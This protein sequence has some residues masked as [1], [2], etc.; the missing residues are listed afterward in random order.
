MKFHEAMKALE[1]GK[2]VRYSLSPCEHWIDKSRLLQWMKYLAKQE[3]LDCNKYEWELYEEPHKTYTFMEVVQGLKE[4]K[5]FK[6]KNFTGWIETNKNGMIFSFQEN[7]SLGSRYMTYI[8][9]YEAT[10]WIEVT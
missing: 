7:D 3:H 4:G 2:R 6:R 5:K 9:D 8:S 10:D 1:E